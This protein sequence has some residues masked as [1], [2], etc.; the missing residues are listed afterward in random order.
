MTTQKI[1]INISKEEQDKIL[2]L[3]KEEMRSLGSLE[4]K[5]LQDYLKKQEIQNANR[6]NYPK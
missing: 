4:R 6:R 1:I 5:A 3:A 2:N